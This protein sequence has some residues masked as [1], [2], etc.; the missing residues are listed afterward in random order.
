MLYRFANF[1]LDSA[2]YTL[3]ASDVPVDLPPKSAQLLAM[4]VERANT[5]ITKT[6][7]MDALWPD[8][9]V[10]ESN[11]TQHVY[12]LRRA[13]R[14]HGCPAQIET[15]PRRGYR[16]T[17]PAPAPRQ[18]RPRTPAMRGAATIAAAL[19]LLILAAAASTTRPSAAALSG[20]ALHAYTMGR[21]FWNL[22]SVSGMQRSVAYFRRTL[23]LAPRS[24]LG[25]AALA[26]A[27]TELADFEQPC[28][29]CAKWRRG[30]ERAAS[31][32]LALDPSSAEAHAAYAM[33]RRV[34]YN[35]E[36][37]AAAELRKALAIDPKNALANQWYGNMLVAQGFPAAGVRHL[38]IAAAQ[39]PIATATY[40]W[41]AR[42]YYDERRYDE[43]VRYAREAL[44]LEPTRLETV[45]L[46]GEAQE[47]RG[48]TRAAVAEFEVAAR[49]G[50][51]AAE[52]QA[53]LAGAQAASGRRAPALVTLRRLAARDNL[54]V[55]AARDVVIGFTL[56]GDVRDARAQLARMKFA[57][58]L[59]REL[60][61]ADPHVGALQTLR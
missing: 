43:A 6:E 5:V 16:F 47:A 19:L 44:A 9:F 53:L 33:V 59:D 29:Q 31:Q 32:S 35:D 36:R 17:A 50:A 28:G 51:S 12:L 22:R 41:I 38:Q 3:R 52:V 55:Y 18:P 39:Q 45:V 14:Q 57:S 61:L 23:S 27:Y 49:G 15:A 56:A 26:D 7:L 30:A 42:G 25:Y 20:D 11:L 48:N 2:S 37:T 40:A 8:G 24:A 13:L 46:L 58:R 54:D 10:E 60:V 4:L 21:Y 34:F 1:V